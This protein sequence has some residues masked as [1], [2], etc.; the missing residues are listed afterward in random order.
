QF[1]A[2]DLDGVAAGVG[3]EHH[4]VTDLDGQRTNFTI[5]QNAT[6]AYGNDLATV[7]LL[8]GRARQ[9]DA[10]SGFAFFFAATDDDAVVQRTKC[11]CRFL[12]SSCFQPVNATGPLVI[13]AMPERRAAGA[14]RKLLCRGRNL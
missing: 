11:H 13:P 1:L 2:V 4:L 14:P 6:S 10:T 3:A 7:R 12:P 5:V 9:H 8:G